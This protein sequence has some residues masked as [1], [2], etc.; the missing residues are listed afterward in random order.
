MA[1]RNSFSK[2][3]LQY[4]PVPVV[5][6]RPDEKR[7]KKRE[8]RDNDPDKWS[9][10]QMLQANKGIHEADS[11]MAVDWQIESKLSADEEAGRVARA[12]GLP[13]KF[14]PTLKRY[15]PERQRSSLS[16][17]TTLGDTGRLVSTPTITPTASAANSEDEGSG[18]EEEEGEGEFEVASGARLI[19]AQKQQEIEEKQ[20]EQEQKERLHEMEVGEAAALLK[21]KPEE[22]E[23][24]EEEDDDEDDEDGG[25]AV[26]TSSAE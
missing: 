19:Q 1:T 24:E 20:K 9:Y 2:Y 7:Q 3:C 21:H 26:N 4:S 18:D 15:K 22:L 8:K 23:D 10:R 16:V 6:V 5:V 11:D 14:D 13:A 12:L 25:G 17:T